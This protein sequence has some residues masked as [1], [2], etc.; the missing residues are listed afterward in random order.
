MSFVH[1]MDSDSSSVHSRLLAIC[2][3]VW[4][5]GFQTMP[6]AV[7]YMLEILLNSGHVAALYLVNVVS[8]IHAECRAC[9]SC[10]EAK[11]MQHHPYRLTLVFGIQKPFDY[12]FSITETQCRL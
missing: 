11:N 8:P 1:V 6:T 9:R 3:I 7:G 5:E 2:R 4:E 12:P 10:C